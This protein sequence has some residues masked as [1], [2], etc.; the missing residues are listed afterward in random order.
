MNTV[1]D[2]SEPTGTPASSLTRGYV[3]GYYGHLLSWQERITILHTLARAGFNTYLYAPKEDLNHRFEWRREYETQWRSEFRNFT[4]EAQQLG[5]QV[6]AGIAPGLD[7]NFQQLTDNSCSSQTEASGQK[8]DLTILFEKS[9]QLMNDGA[10]AIALLMDDIDEN[11]PIHRGGFQSEGEAHASLANSMYEHLLDNNNACNAAP[12]PALYC[13]PRI[14]ANELVVENDLTMP[15]HKTDASNHKEAHLVNDSK[16]EA[17]AYLHDFTDT[18]NNG[19][20]WIYCGRHVVSQQPDKKHCTEISATLRHRIVIWDNF[21]A[22]DYCPRRLFLGP[23]YGRENVVDVLINGTGLPHTDQLLLDIVAAT[24]AQKNKSTENLQ[25]R[26]KECVCAA[27]VPDDFF[28]LQPY[29]DRPVFSDSADALYPDETSDG[30]DYERS[31]AAIDTLLWQWKTPLARE[32]YPYLFG[33]KHDLM[34]ATGNLP[35]LRVQKTQTKALAA[36]INQAADSNQDVN[37][38]E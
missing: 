13:V 33:L 35:R 11:F 19:I 16:N 26:W 15:A 37:S 27:G 29:F 21:Y 25:Q 9:L 17:S 28:V 7:F 2:S 24:D 23:W 30:I 20:A 18:L 8:G 6:I 10:T 34:I 4:K 31:L 5:V 22:N 1:P 32:W 14:Y 12:A 38:A 3:E 36:F